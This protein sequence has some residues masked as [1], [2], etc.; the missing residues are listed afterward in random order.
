VS[1]RLA[2]LAV[3]RRAGFKRRSMFN[4]NE[5]AETIDLH[6]RSY[7]LLKWVGRNLRGGK[8]EFSVV[9]EAV[10]NADAANEWLRRHWHNLPASGRPLENQLDAF[11]HL[12]ASYLTTSFKL[13]EAPRNRVVSYCGC[14]CTYCTYLG[15]ADRL[16]VRS[17]SK[18]AKRAAD[19]LKKVYLTY[20]ASEHDR[21]LSIPQVETLIA[22]PGLREALA[23]A[24]YSHELIR[25]TKFASQGEGVLALWRQ[26]A[27]TEKGAI[28]VKFKL[29]VDTILKAESRVVSHLRAV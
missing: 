15:Q 6:Q 27:W 20:L 25:R 21:H 16:Q 1:G 8:L 18:G 2:E 3:G 19:E 24:T 14:W 7:E 23:M 11:A 12:F 9:H 4:P 5:L 29:D 13:I 26:F 22:D 10:S 28:K 17:P